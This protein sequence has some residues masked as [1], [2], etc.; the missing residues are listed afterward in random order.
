MA[1]LLTDGSELAAVLVVVLVAFASV[2][3]AALMA[4]WLMAALRMAACVMRSGF[5]SVAVAIA[6]AVA[7]VLVVVVALMLL[8]M[9]LV[10]VAVALAA[11]LVAVAVALVVV[12][13]AFWV[14]WHASA[15]KGAAGAWSLG[16]ALAIA[17]H[18]P[19]APPAMAELPTIAC[20]LGLAPAA[21]H[22]LAASLS[23]PP[24]PHPP[25][26]PPQTPPWPRPPRP[27]WPRPPP[28]YPQGWQIGKLTKK[29]TPAIAS[30]HTRQA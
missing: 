13:Q 20:R 2:A 26:H 24:W 15:H 11:G 28:H 8:V 3:L 10:T 7:L 18:G 17:D 4:A 9:A 22:V 29:G 21:T 25:H 14:G 5:V 23:L 1:C 27:R 19:M 30:T 16:V 6:A 12:A